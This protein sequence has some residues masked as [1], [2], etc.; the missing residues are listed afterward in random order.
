MKFRNVIYLFG[1]LALLSCTNDDFR[2]QDEEQTSLT[3]RRVRFSA[4]VA[5]QFMTRATQHHDGS[6]NEGDQM[7]IFRQYAIGSGGSVFDG[8]S[9]S[10]RTYYFKMDYA[11]GTTVSLHSDWFPMDGKLKSDDPLSAPTTQTEADSLVWENGR[12]VR[13]RAWGRSNLDDAINIGTRE[14]YYPDYT[15]SSALHASHCLPYRSYLQA[16]QRVRGSS[17]LYRLARLQ[18]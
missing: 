15:V 7:R 13:F 11:T 12:T 8:E 5:D 2:I 10:F 6:F 1:A 17:H 16:G 4:S 9:E 14:S 3:G 18:A